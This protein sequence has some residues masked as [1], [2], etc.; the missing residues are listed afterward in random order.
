[1]RRFAALPLL[2]SAVLA[3]AL[4]SSVRPA[5]A[6][7]ADSSAFRIAHVI[8]PSLLVTGGI[9]IHC[10][11]HESWDF[12]VREYA[13]ELRGEMEA[14][15][16]DDFVQFLPLAMDLSLGA[17][18]AECE[19]RFGRRTV[20]AAIAYAAS[21]ALVWTGKFTVRSLRPNEK[22][23]RSFPSGH[24][25]VAFT[26][27]ELVRLE[28]GW[29]WGLGAYAVAATIGGMRIWRNW[30]WLSDVV[31]GA[32]IG[33]FCADLGRWLLDPACDLL[34]PRNS[35]GVSDSGGPVATMSFAPSF[36]PVSG[37]VVPGLALRF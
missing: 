34:R 5:S 35:R 29:D 25:A 32:G 36:D 22:N 23:Y 21:T 6:Q 20:E 9:S 28:Y 14:V 15:P 12:S 18:G 19:N 30:H 17:L 37:S 7:I 2:R 10:L 3:L 13:R 16:F 31:A 27:A 33:V 4:L 11:A 8:A 1:M 24:T 26:G